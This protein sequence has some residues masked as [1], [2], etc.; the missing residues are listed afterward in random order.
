MLLGPES[1]AQAAVGWCLGCPQAAVSD[2]FPQLPFWEA[3][4]SRGLTTQALWQ[5]ELSK[6][7]GLLRG[8]LERGPGKLQQ[9]H[10]VHA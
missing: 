1:T 4:E 5:W 9:T 7:C 10:Q 6:V 2:A 8:P 3:T